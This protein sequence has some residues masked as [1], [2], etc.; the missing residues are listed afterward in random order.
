MVEKSESL[1]AFDEESDAAD[2]ADTDLMSGAVRACMFVVEMS[3]V[4]NEIMFRLMVPVAYRTVPLRLGV[5]TSSRLMR[6]VKALARDIVA[7]WLIRVADE[8]SSSMYGVVT[9]W[10]KSKQINRQSA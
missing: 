8:G 5:A 2:V 7:V 6:L 3:S 10:T 4:G 1:P 9:R